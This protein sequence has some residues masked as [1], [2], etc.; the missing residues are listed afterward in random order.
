MSEELFP[1][2]DPLRPDTWRNWPSPDLS[3]FN[4]ALLDHFGLND[5]GQPHMRAEWGQT[6]T[7]FQRGKERLLYVDTRIP[8]LETFVHILKRTVGFE[9]HRTAVSN[10]RG[11]I[12]VQTRLV[13]VWEQMTVAEEPAIIP[14]GWL[15]EKQVQLEW[16]GEQLVY[17]EQ[18]FPPHI[19]ARG[20]TPES[21]ERNRY[22][23]WVDPEIGMVRG[24]DI[25]GPFPS[26]GRYEC[27]RIVGEPYSYP[28]YVD[29]IEWSDVLQDFVPVKLTRE[30]KHLKFRMPDRETLDALI[31]T[32][33][34]REN[35]A[36]KSLHQLALERGARLAAQAASKRFKRR[37]DGVDAMR[38]VIKTCR[39]LN[40]EKVVREILGPELA[41]QHNV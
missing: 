36:T 35:R 40:G 24:C 21:W 23:D 37:R 13:P 4:Q 9:E 12:D 25:I 15:Y 2:V 26:E 34:E 30:G 10:W 5:Y 19:C 11:E 18:W 14:E 29:D 28:Y 20:D 27:V 22:E 7:H 1:L 33:H 3:D 41:A 8:A 38:D 31:E 39:G 16:I 6:R 32:E 17:V